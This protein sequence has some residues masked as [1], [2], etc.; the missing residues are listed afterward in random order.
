MTAGKIEAS[1]GPKCAVIRCPVGN[2][3]EVECQAFQGDCKMCVV[4]PRLLPRGRFAPRCIPP[5]GREIENRAVPIP[6][7]RTYANFVCV[8]S[9]QSG[10]GAPSLQTDSPLI[11]IFRPA[12]RLSGRRGEHPHRKLSRAASTVKK[13]GF[14]GIEEAAGWP[15]SYKPVERTQRGNF[16]G[17]SNMLGLTKR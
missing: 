11:S 15:G 9:R 17:P 13:A 8:R 1:E 12:E 16:T 14:P 10:R 5:A 6:K 2:V 7:G 3:H 4:I